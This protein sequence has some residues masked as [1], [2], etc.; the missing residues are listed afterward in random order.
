MPCLNGVLHFFESVWQ[1]IWAVVVP[2]FIATFVGAWAAFRLQTKKD[3]AKEEERKFLAGKRAQFVLL[4]KYNTLLLFQTEYLEKYKDDQNRSITLPATP[5]NIKQPTLDLEGLLF[6]L[7]SDDPN[8]LLEVV[9]ADQ[10]FQGVVNHANDRSAMHIRFQENQTN[11]AVVNALQQM[12]DELYYIIDNAIQDIEKT[13]NNLREFLQKRFPNRSPLGLS[14][15]DA[16]KD[17]QE[18]PVLPV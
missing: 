1:A 18:S 15:S 8:L 10:L 4:T 5:I 6:I 11:H 16:G 14:K 7:N 3:E 9:I 17:M 12:T 13:F 2:T